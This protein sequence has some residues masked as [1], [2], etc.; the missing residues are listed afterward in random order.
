MSVVMQ[1]HISNV[2]VAGGVSLDE[3]EI[4]GIDDLINDIPTVATM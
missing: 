3:H 2:S 1:E 4:F